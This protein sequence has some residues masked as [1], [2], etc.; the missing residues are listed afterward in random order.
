MLSRTWL[1]QG[2]AA[3]V[4]ASTDAFINFIKD[5]LKQVLDQHNGYLGTAGEMKQL[6]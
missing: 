5:I 1:P 6:T 2:T 4:A 3:A